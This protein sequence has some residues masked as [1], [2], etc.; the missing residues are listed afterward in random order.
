M[1]VSVSGT[2]SNVVD[3]DSTRTAI[4]DISTL[5]GA[6]VDQG[7]TKVDSS[8]GAMML[9]MTLTSCIA[10]VLGLLLAMA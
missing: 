5:D 6:T 7:Q 1:Q 2:I 10:L 3:N 4:K 9:H 8:S